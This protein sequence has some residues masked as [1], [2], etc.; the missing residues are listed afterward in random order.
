MTKLYEEIKIQEKDNNKYFIF[1]FS[2]CLIFN[3][4]MSGI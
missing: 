1:Q 4:D 3:L 2:T